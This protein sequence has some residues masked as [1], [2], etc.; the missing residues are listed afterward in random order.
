MTLAGVYHPNYE[1][2]LPTENYNVIASGGV[3]STAEDLVTFSR[4]FTGEVDGILS[5]RSVKA[6]E[7]AEYKRGIW[8]PEEADSSLSYGLGWDSVNLF[9]FNQYGIK[10]I[11]KGGDTASYHSSL[12]VLPEYNMSAA[13]VS[14]GGSSA[15]DKLLAIE[16]LLSALQE[17]GIIKERKPEKSHGVPIKANMPQE[18]SQH[19]GLYGG[20]AGAIMKIEMNPVGELAVSTITTPNL[21]IIDANKAANRLQIPGMA[22]RDSLELRRG[23]VS[24]TPW[25]AVTIKLCCRITEGLYLLERSALYLRFH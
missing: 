8:P 19:A 4:I 16:L 12:V 22:G 11:T 21:K 10:A 20:A 7:Q 3:Y 17:K 23:Y 14:S 24:I 2:Q 13:V 25:S 5:P 15:T 9:P 18:L 1:G 6:M